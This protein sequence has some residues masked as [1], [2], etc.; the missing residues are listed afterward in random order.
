MWLTLALV[1]LP[2][3]FSL[4]KWQQPTS[5][6]WPL[7]PFYFT[8]DLFYYSYNHLHSSI[9]HTLKTY[10]DLVGLKKQHLALLEENKRLQSQLNLF[11]DLQ[12]ENQRLTNLLQLQQNQQ[13]N[14]LA[15]KVLSHDI[16]AHRS[17]IIINRGSRQGVKSSMA[18]V[19]NQG[20]VGYVVQVQRHS[21]RVLLLTDRH[22]VVDAMLQK[23]RSR[24]LVRSL[25]GQNLPTSFV[26]LKYLQKDDPVD[27]GDL[28][29]T[30]GR[31]QNFPKGLPIGQVVEVNKNSASQ[32]VR[33]KTAANL[34]ALEEL[35]ILKQ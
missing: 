28:V 23:T 20:L 21:S 12:K 6:P 29:I 5:R 17:S 14:L 27:K 34:L 25:E 4:D 30:S 2:F 35:F 16:T 26:Q 13:L 18:A 22:A 31:D 10:I 15:A 33:L 9:D 3:F 1:I 24:G 7:L 19:S 8:A 32:F 11:S